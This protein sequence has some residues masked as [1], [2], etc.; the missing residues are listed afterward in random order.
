MPEDNYLYFIFREEEIACDGSE[1]SYPFKNLSKYV[2]SKKKQI[3]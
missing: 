3:S 1:Q 2:D